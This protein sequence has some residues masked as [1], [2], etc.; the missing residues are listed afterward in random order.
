M[1]FCHKCG[2]EIKGN[3]HSFAGHGYYVEYHPECCPKEMED[4]HCHL[5]HPEPKPKRPPIKSMLD[6][7]AYWMIQ[8]DD[9]EFTLSSDRYNFIV[10][11]IEKRH[12][13]TKWIDMR[14]SKMELER[15]GEQFMC[16]GIVRLMRQL[17]RADPTLRQ[18][19]EH[20]CNPDEPPIDQEEG[21]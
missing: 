1:T 6:L 2:K 7:L 15:K 3:S 21:P 12:G 9:R 18:I 20:F 4:I 13:Y 16:E 5:D 10:K 17:E 11:L 14:I 8:E 19:A